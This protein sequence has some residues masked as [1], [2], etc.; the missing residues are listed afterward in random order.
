MILKNKA[1]LDYDHFMFHWNYSII[2][3]IEETVDEIEIVEKIRNL[4]RAFFAADEEDP[5]TPIQPSKNKK[6]SKDGGSTK[7]KK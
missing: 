5:T 6:N 3:N 7:K 4:P 1:K 2:P